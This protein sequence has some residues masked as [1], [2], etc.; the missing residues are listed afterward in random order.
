[1]AT[2]AVRESTPDDVPGVR[3][4][5]RRGWEAAYGDVLD[6]ATIERALEEWYAPAFVRES[7]ER[8]DVVH[9]VAV[10]ESGR[11]GAVVGYTGGWVPD[12]DDPERGVVGT[13]YVDPDR[14]GAGIGTRL[15]ERALDALRGQGV[16]RVTIRVLAENAVG[17][18]FYESRGFEV[19]AESAD[20]LFGETRPAVTYASEI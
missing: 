8:A 10:D 3:R 20:D 1:M 11:D 4:V 18:S 17:R 14:W 2:I 12:A 16:T 5:A 7:V 13:L 15:F 19:A 6:P 9:L